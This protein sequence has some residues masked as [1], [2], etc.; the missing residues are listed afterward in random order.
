[1][2]FIA[3]EQNRILHAGA[4]LAV[5][6]GAAWTKYWLDVWDPCW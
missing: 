3:M 1:M 5:S 6:I 4:L 2:L